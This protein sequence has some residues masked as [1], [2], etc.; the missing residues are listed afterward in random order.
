MTSIFDDMIAGQAEQTEQTEATNA[1]AETAETN[2]SDWPKT[3]TLPAGERPEG[4]ETVAEF[5]DRVNKA[6]V[7]ER[8]A[9]LIAQDVDAAD[10]AVQA[11]ADQVNQASFYQAVKAQRNP[12]PHYVVQYEVPVLDAEGNETGE[13]KTE[14]KTF[15]PIDVALDWWKN[16]PTRG[17]G[18]AARSEEDVE[19]R[20]IKAGKKLADLN[21]ARERLTKLEANIKRM[22]GQVEKYQEWLAADGKTLED[23]TAAYEKA[24]EA[25]EAEKAIGDNE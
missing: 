15:V 21:S 22:E 10:A 14:E 3:V 6:R 7:R 17:G 23:A 5:A 19:K 25:E 1:P 20:L 12:M 2:A 9:E 8:V 13:T 4:S 16:R 18:G 24:V 11:L